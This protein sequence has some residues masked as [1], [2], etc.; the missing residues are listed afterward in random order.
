MDALSDVVYIAA[1]N[2]GEVD[3]AGL[4]QVDMLLL[5]QE[6]HLLICDSHRTQNS[7]QTQGEEVH[8]I[9]SVSI[10]GGPI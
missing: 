4:G 3:P 6:L 2:A 8:R 7:S 10:C 5:D 1:V 9:R